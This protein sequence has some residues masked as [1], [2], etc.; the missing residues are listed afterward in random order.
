MFQTTPMIR[1]FLIRINPPGVAPGYGAALDVNSWAFRDL[2]IG[3]LLLTA[4]LLIRASLTIESKTVKRT[5]TLAGMAGG[6]LLVLAF[7]QIWG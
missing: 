2:A 5:A 4:A 7:V 6:V 3:T 1:A